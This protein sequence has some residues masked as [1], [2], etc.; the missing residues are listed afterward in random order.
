MDF[1]NFP[2]EGGSTGSSEK[3]QV[4]YND[5]QIA[6][7]SQIAAG[8]MDSKRASWYIS[9]QRVS[10]LLCHP[11]FSRC[12]SLSNVECFSEGNKQHYA[13]D[14]LLKCHFTVHQ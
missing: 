14:S 11:S 1:P 5:R 3:L 2:A 6:F 9:G 7:F 10:A 8:N 4:Q 13:L 12:W